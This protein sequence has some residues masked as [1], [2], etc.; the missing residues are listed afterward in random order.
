MVTR[1]D[2]R[3][4][5][6]LMQQLGGSTAAPALFGQ[7]VLRP[8]DAAQLPARAAARDQYAALVAAGAG[9]TPPYPVRAAM[10]DWDFAAATTRIQAATAILARDDL[11]PR[12]R[13]STS[14]CRAFERST[15]RQGAPDIAGTGTAPVRARRDRARAQ[16][17]T[18][19]RT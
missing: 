2:S 1:V 12:P 17:W 18:A 4:L 9:W 15:R 19:I 6:D 7:Y 11:A 14:P 8:E 3:R 10:S 16:P 5:L 13:R